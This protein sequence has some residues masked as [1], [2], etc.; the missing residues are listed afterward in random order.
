MQGSNISSTPT[1]TI[2]STLG[3]G[4]KVDNIYGPKTTASV[5]AF[6]SANGLKVDGI[7]GPKTQAAFNAKY[8][9]TAAP[10]SSLIT[11]SGPSQTQFVQNSSALNT[12]LSRYAIAPNSSTD[13]PA[14]PNNAA[15]ANDGANPKPTPDPILNDTVSGTPNDPYIQQLDAM[16]A[17][18][19]TATQA[20]V[21]NIKS[22]KAKQ[23]AA[24]DT[25]YNNYKSGLELLGIQTN[26]A[27]VT[28]DLLMSHI[29]QAESEH[30]DKLATLDNEEVKALSDAQTAQDNNDFK[31]LNEK[32][33]YLK[34]IQAEKTTALKNY[35]TALTTQAKNAK[36][37]GDATSKI[38]APDIYSTLQTLDPADQEPFLIAVSQKFN[39]PLASLVTSLVAQ[40]T[41]SDKAAAT[42]VLSPSEA[43]TLGVPYGT[44]KADAAKMNITPKTAAKS[45]TV[46]SAA[47]LKAAENEISN[48]LKTGKDANG[49]VLGNPKGSDG[50]VD[51]GVYLQGLKNWPGTQKEFLAKF[52]VVGTVNPASYS[53][54]PAAVQPKAKT[55]SN[56]TS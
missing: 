24:V 48:A 10:T 50:Y 49:N 39:I 37:Q 46:S 51:P 53:K 26:A 40:K 36:T 38:I 11:T 16:S 15:P 23:S 22:I 2:Q 3:G 47:Q 43:K 12:A 5:Q 56:R 20:L 1:S 14:S 4:L 42:A 27:S 28:P 13:N 7:F 17:R 9:N 33:T 34:Q 18:G 32:M 25:Q 31:T 30:Q 55:T 35:Q 44:T 21:S 45:K 52:P 19:N 8:N 29:N 54:L 41:V 6:Q